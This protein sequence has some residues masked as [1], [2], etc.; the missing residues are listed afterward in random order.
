MNLQVESVEGS[1][2]SRR[3]SSAS[4]PAAAGAE[5]S[6]APEPDDSFLAPLT[7]DLRIDAQHQIYYAVVNDRTGEVVLEIPPEVIRELAESLDVPLAG[8]ASA[9]SLDVKS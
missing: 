7:T 6:P 3:S 1:T 9:H 8:I 4:E 5:E 2:A